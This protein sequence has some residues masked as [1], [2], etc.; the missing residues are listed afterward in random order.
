MINPICETRVPY[1]IS[2]GGH[3]PLWFICRM[4]VSGNTDRCW[5]TQIHVGDVRWGEA[6]EEME[7]EA[8]A[9]LEK[10]SEIN[11]LEWLLQ[12]DVSIYP[13]LLVYHHR[14]INYY[15]HSQKYLFNTRISRALR[16]GAKIEVFEFDRIYAHPA[17]SKGEVRL[18]TNYLNLFDRDHPNYSKNVEICR[19]ALSELLSAL[20]SGLL[21]ARGYRW[22]KR[23]G[24]TRLSTMEPERVLVPA[25]AWLGSQSPS[26]KVGGPF[27]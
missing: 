22:E 6:D 19:V 1:S 10:Q 11:R 9:D 13:T 2:Q 16:N 20:S 17:H 15:T 5:A 8:E 24:E 4:A 25:S 14:K 18:L 26:G 7:A 12:E 27:R 23:L 21:Q 3:L